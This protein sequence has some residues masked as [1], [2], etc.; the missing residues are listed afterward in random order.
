MKIASLTPVL[1]L[2]LLVPI[3]S[4][5]KERYKTLREKIPYEKLD[6]LE[7]EI[8]IGVADLHIGKVKENNL[9]EANIRYRVEQGEPKITFRRSGEVGYLTIESGDEDRDWNDDSPK[10]GGETWE[11]LFSPEI[12]TQFQMEIGLVDG[13]IDLSGLRVTDLYISGGLSD[14]DLVFNEPNPEEIDNI[15]IEV[16]LGEFNA[17][18]LGNANFRELDLE[19]G[20]GSAD[21]DL[22][23][24]WRVEE[25]EMDVEVGLGKAKIN[26][27]AEI[28]LEVFKD[29]NFLSS[30]SLDRELQLVR[31]GLYRTANWDDARHRLSIATDV[32]LGSVKVKIVE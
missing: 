14:A 17:N 2:L 22:S 25:A 28:G 18:G 20:L 23:G 4:D 8:S 31:K 21:L 13:R 11:L 15:R 1:C 19:C 7:V 5:A 6:R 24:Q 10:K 12:K 30:V 29:E 32:G 9:L 16:G 26:V 27:P 3:R